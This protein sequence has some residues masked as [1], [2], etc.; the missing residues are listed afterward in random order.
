MYTHNSHI[1][2]CQ[3]TDKST[4]C[5][6]A[7]G[8]PEQINIQLAGSNIVVVSFVTFQQ[9]LPSLPPQAVLTSADGADTPVTGVAHWYT[10]SHPKEIARNYVMNFVKFANLTA[11][12]TYSYKVCVCLFIFVC[13]PLSVSVSVSV[14]LSD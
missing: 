3:H 10:T 9:S 6:S 7:D 5:S 13:Q 2:S 1:D 8:V 4:P 11:R 12:A 14:Y